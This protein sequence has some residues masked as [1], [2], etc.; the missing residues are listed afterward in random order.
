MDV[1]K[2]REIEVRYSDD[3]IE[4]WHAWAVAV[5]RAILRDEEHAPR[6]NARCPDCPIRHTCPVFL[7]LP[8]TAFAT[9]EAANPQSDVDRLRW[10]DEA[11]RMRLVL[12]KAVATID[13]EFRSRA[14]H[15]GVLRVGDTEWTVETDWKWTPDMLALHAA[16]GDDFYRVVSVTK[17]ALNRATRQYPPDRLAAVN[18]AISQV[19]DGTKVVKRKVK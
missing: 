9:V 17:T 2:F 15:D 16:L 8:A 6:L 5:A 19:P 18:A 4:D 12:E 1:V 13:E 11:N 7:N 14:E 3:Q 10:R